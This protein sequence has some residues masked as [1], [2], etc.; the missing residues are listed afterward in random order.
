[1][2]AREFQGLGSFIERTTGASGVP[3]IPQ[4]PI[5]LAAVAAIVNADKQADRRNQ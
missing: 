1:M 4:D 2:A 5:A 3:F